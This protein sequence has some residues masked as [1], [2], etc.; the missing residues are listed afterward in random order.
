MN[1]NM[2]TF[3]VCTL[4]KHAYIFINARYLTKQVV[5][6]ELYSDGTQFES[7]LDTDETVFVFFF[8]LPYYLQTQPNLI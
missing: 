5:V 3:S 2:I 1:S 7:T 4:T 6:A 8:S